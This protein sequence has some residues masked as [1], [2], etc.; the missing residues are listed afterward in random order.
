MR[1]ENIIVEKF[2]KLDINDYIYMLND[3]LIR[4]KKIDKVEGDDSTEFI[5]IKLYNAQNDKFEFEV[6]QKRLEYGV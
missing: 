5:R 6:L 2:M 1:I 4:I 3:K